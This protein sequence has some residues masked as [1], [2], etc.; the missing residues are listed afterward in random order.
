MAFGGLFG[1]YCGGIIGGAYSA[2]HRK[3]NVAALDAGKVSRSILK[4]VQKEPLLAFASIKFPRVASI[5][6]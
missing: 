3:E 1:A 2:V 4:D 6:C 5:V